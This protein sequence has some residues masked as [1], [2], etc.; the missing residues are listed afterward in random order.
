MRNRKE[1]NIDEWNFF[2]RGSPSDFSKIPNSIDYIDQ[3]RFIGLLGLEESHANFR[4]LIK[5]F[6]DPTDKISWKDVLTKDEAH[7]V[8]LPAIYEDRLSNF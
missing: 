5:S 2:L 4:D 8:E 6:Q 7:L 3:E 1:I